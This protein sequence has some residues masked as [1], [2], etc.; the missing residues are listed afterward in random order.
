M[1]FREK[2]A[3]TYKSPMGV[4]VNVGDFVKIGDWIGFVQDIDR[5]YSRWRATIYLFNYP[6]GKGTT[7]VRNL[8]DIN[9][10]WNF[11]LYEP[12]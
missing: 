7:F 5:P 8:A 10:S 11:Q 3:L 4:I 6:H 9:K 1:G 2:E 12:P